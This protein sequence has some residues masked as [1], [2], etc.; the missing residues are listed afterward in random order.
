MALCICGCGKVTSG[1][2]S[3]YCRGHNLNAHRPVL[4]RFWLHVR[5]SDQCW[6]WTASLVDGYGLI[7]DGRSKVYV[8]RYSYQLHCGAIP[9]GVHVLHTCDNRRCVR[10]DH[11]FLGTQTDN[12]RDMVSKGR[13]ANVCGEA[14]P[15]A[16]LTDADV[17]DIRLMRAAKCSRA[18]V[19]AKH[20]ISEGMVTLI[21]SGKAWSVS[22]AA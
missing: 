15:N 6:E 12:M 21:T 18:E 7:R 9:D 5:K 1:P 10:P 20:G 14:N 4:E 13:N 16:K 8:H 17:A 3:Q 22:S 11:L 2:E 19:A